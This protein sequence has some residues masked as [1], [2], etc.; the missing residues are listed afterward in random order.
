M[1]TRC[2]CPWKST[3]LAGEGFCWVQVVEIGLLHSCN[4]DPLSLKSLSFLYG[5]HF[6]IMGCWR[7]RLVRGPRWRWHWRDRGSDDLASYAVV[8]ETIA[9]QWAGLRP[10]RSGNKERG[11]SRG[12]MQTMLDYFCDTNVLHPDASLR[13]VP[14]YSTADFERC[15][16]FRSFYLPWSLLMLGLL[17]R[18]FK[19]AWGPSVLVRWA[20]DLT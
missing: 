17:W 13:K 6:F 16:H 1:F 7:I 20:W 3:K 14:M 11:F 9:L 15:F 12:R 19:E 10:G 4:W 18:F 2:Q 8:G 5:T